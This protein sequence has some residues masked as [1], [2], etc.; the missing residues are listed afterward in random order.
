MNTKI[1]Y[2]VLALAGAIVPYF[3]SCNTSVKQGSA[4][5]HSSALCSLT[6]PRAASAQIF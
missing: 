3:F 1:L 5:R 2:L 6:V 4:C